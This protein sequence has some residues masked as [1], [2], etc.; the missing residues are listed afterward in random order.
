M[1]K[2]RMSLE[3]K[4]LAVP[5]RPVIHAA[6][7]DVVGQVIEI[8]QSRLLG[9]RIAL[10]DPDE[11]DVPDRALLAVSV[12]EIEQRSANALDGWNGE[13]HRA[14][15]AFEGLGAQRQRAVIG[16]LGI[17]DAE[18]HGAGAWPMLG[19]ELLGERIGLGIDDEV[20]VALAPERDLLGPMLRDRLEAHGAEQLAEL[21]RL[22]MGVFDEFETVRAHRIGFGDGGRG[23]SCGNGP[24]ASLHEYPQ[25]A[26][27]VM[28]PAKARACIFAR[29]CA[30]L[31]RICAWI[32]QM[33]QNIAL[34]A[35]DCG[36]STP[37]S[38]MRPRPML[39]SPRRSASRPAR[40]PGGASGSRRRGR[41]AATGRCRSG[42]DRARRDRLHPCRA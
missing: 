32:M 16:L 2:K 11:I 17:D 39:C 8:M 33:P 24:M 9:L 22:G 12:D 36:C 38:R 30:I 31:A 5:V 34:D 1:L 6:A 18:G 10:A 4:E 15:L 19:R 14:D 42:R 40:F 25:T 41:S 29:I 20:D 21:F 37:C 28:A 26:N 35:L 3:V 7:M 27:M 13:L 23:A